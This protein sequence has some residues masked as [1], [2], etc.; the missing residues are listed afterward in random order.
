ML[1][2]SVSLRSA[3]YAEHS[4]PEPRHARWNVVSNQLPIVA[5]QL[6]STRSFRPPSAG[7]LCSHTAQVW[8]LSA[9]QLLCWSLYLHR[10]VPT[11]PFVHF[12][13]S[14]NTKSAPS[15]HTHANPFASGLGTLHLNFA[16]FLSI[17]FS[18]SLSRSVSPCGRKLSTPQLDHANVRA[19]E[20]GKLTA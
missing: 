11:V 15:T 19:T 3:G 16:L 18:H 10:D 12:I 13:F 2:V 14:R 6:F 7:A 4:F 8:L 9:L 1:C 17:C 20:S 5:G